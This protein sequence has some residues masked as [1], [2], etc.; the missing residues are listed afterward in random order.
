MA[1]VID[2]VKKCEPALYFF[3]ITLMDTDCGIWYYWNDIGKTF[4]EY[5]NSS[6]LIKIS[7]QII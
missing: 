4:N 7:T 3:F 2:A 1:S 6:I 5:N